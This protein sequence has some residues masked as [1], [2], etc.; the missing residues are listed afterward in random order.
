[1]GDSVVVQLADFSCSGG[2][3]GV[4]FGDNDCG[5]FKRAEGKGDE[6]VFAED[7]V[8]GDCG[9]GGVLPVTSSLAPFV[10]GKLGFGD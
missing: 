9:D 4:P 8:V 2:V 3:V 5:D 7:F 10:E 6:C 1:M